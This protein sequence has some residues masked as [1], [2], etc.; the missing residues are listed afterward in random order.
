MKKFMKTKKAKVIGIVLLLLIVG[1]IFSSSGE[2]EETFEVQLGNGSGIDY[3]VDVQL[4]DVMK[5]E[6]SIP[7]GDYTVTNLGEYPCQISIYTDK[8]QT[9]DEGYTEQ[10]SSDK[11]PIMLKVDESTPVHINSN[12]LIYLGECDG[13]YGPAWVEFSK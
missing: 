10:V 8:K 13:N 12:D 4:D 11:D 5:T 7:E 3:M 2:D 6:Y 9:T 1:C